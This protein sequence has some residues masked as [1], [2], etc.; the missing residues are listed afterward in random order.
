MLNALNE[1]ELDLIRLVTP[2]TDN[3]RLEKILENSSGF[4]YYV[5]ITGITGQHSA[6]INELKLS[7][8]KINKKTN[9]PI[10]SG[11]GIK[12]EKQVSEI[13]KICDG[14]V[15][16]SSLVKIIEENLNNKSKIIKLVSEFVK[17]LKQ[18]T[19]KWIG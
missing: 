4:L 15:V 3:K 7:I 16:G 8:E 5:T 9:L 10:V 13:C 12:D 11:F 18:G 14:A 17:K 6:N 2:T 19:I 1:T